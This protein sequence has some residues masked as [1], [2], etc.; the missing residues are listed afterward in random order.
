MNATLWKRILSMVLC[1]VLTVGL[2]PA[3]VFALDVQEEHSHSTAT[4][5]YV[6][7]GTCGE[8]V[9]WTLDSEGTLTISGTGE[10]VDYSF[11]TAPWY[12]H[13][14]QIKAIHIEEG[15]TSI[16]KTAFYRCSNAELV[17]IPNSVTTVGYAAFYECSSLT[18]VTIPNGVTSIALRTFY[19]CSSLESVTIPDSVTNI[20]EGAFFGC[21]ALTDVTIPVGVTYIAAETFYLCTSLESV[22]IPNGV[23]GIGSDAFYNCSS[24]TSITLP[25]SVMA[26]GSAFREC[27]SLVSIDIPNGVTQI[28]N[29]TFDGCSSLKSVMI[30]DSVTSIGIWAFGH[31][32][33]LDNVRIPDSVTSIDMCAFGECN[34]LKNI[35]IPSSVEFIGDCAFTYCNSLERIWVDPV[36]PY[37]CSDSHG[38][39]FDKQ[40]TNII[41]FPGGAEGDYVI[42]DS[43][44]SFDVN[45]FYQCSKLTSLTIPEGISSLAPYEFFECSS[46]ESVTIPNSVTSI[47]EQAFYSCHKLKSVTIPESVTSIGTEAFMYCI[48]LE[49]V[50]LPERITNI[51]EGAFAYCESL[52]E[53]KI[54]EGITT[55]EKDT[56]YGCKSLQNVKI[57]DGVTSIGY[58]SFCGCSDLSSVTIPVSVTSIGYNAFGSCKSLTDVYYGGT[59]EQWKAIDTPTLNKPIENVT[60]HYNST[61]PQVTYCLEV[62]TQ[63]NTFSVQEDDATHFDV[64][65]LENGSELYDWNCPTVTIADEGVCAYTIEQIDSKYRVNITGRS[66]GQTL[67]TITDST[68]GA[69]IDVPMTV[70]YNLDGVNSY[71]LQDVPKFYPNSNIDGHLLTN[72]YNHRGL[73]INNF[74]SYY[75]ENTDSYHISMNAYNSNYYHGAIDVYD[76][77]GELYRCYQIEK[78]SDV[79]SFKDMGEYLIH[80]IDNAENLLAYDSGTVGK[81]TKLEFDVPAGGF[82][83]ISNNVRASMGTFLYN[84]CDMMLFGL[85][86]TLDIADTHANMGQDLTEEIFERVATDKAFQGA[87]LDLMWEL[88]GNMMGDYVKKAEAVNS[89]EDTL[90]AFYDILKSHMSIETVLAGILGIEEAVLTN[91]GGPAA[92]G[93]KTIFTASK[94]NSYILQTSCMIFAPNTAPIVISCRTRGR[95]D[96]LFG[97]KVIGNLP[98]NS[99]LQVN[100]VVGSGLDEIVDAYMAL[101]TNRSVSQYDCTA[102]SVQVIADNRIHILEAPVQVVIPFDGDVERIVGVIH[103]Q[104]DGDWKRIDYQLVDGEVVLTANSMGRFA[105]IY[106]AEPAVISG[107]ITGDG[108]VNN[109]DLT[110]LFRYL[111]G[112]EV[113]VNEA[114][115]DITGDDAV[116]NKDLTRLFRYLSGYDVEIF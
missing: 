27:S 36:N 71:L 43:V 24:L 25:D 75:V 83:T 37:Y 99:I 107:D 19:Y 112:F 51:A 116:N 4:Q 96:S 50:I 2:L 33:S 74:Q 59:K 85:T 101:E 1:I 55:I 30:P 110:R 44:L 23:V 100:S 60:I 106:E 39:L 6:A 114:A 22:E 64:Y 69:T 57:P 113:E 3:E 70:V 109:K 32:N 10:M 28:V 48:D 16:G 56:F 102:F 53:L 66:I 8:N 31:C 12:S 77:S 115:L 95:G 88:T 5:N 14:E 34:S 92:W 13:R 82:F 58:R 29:Y 35:V 81:E 79:S 21:M 89:M 72:F 104:G 11:K 47:G 61:G 62:Y 97:V 52:T 9:T 49:R 26:I 63:D 91:L 17:T 18:C 20:G 7:E 67:I 90:D 42:P 76:A 46:L 54:P 84:M 108:E 103:K 73:Y 65:L 80:F 40:M 86:M 78:F 93:V 105:V 68:T 94:Y 41:R 15:V 38:V 98:E 45:A 87:I 111:S